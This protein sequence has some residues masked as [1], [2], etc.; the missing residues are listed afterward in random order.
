MTYGELEEL[1]NEAVDGLYLTEKQVAEIENRVKKVG[2]EELPELIEIIHLLR[3][4]L[5]KVQIKF[6]EK[7]QK[8]LS[9]ETEVE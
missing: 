2:V 8:F 6:T 4:V 1:F 9:G 3:S 7:Q 5:S